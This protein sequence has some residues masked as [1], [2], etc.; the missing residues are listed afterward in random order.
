MCS[1][2]TEQVESEP[3]GFVF[4]CIKIIYNIY[5][6]IYFFILEC[7]SQLSGFASEV[8]NIASDPGQRDINL[9]TGFEEQQYKFN[10]VRV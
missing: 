10:I 8:N 6:N 1:C 7:G 2:Y 5:I 4:W 9:I 3:A